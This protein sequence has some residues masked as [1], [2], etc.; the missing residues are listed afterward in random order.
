MAMGM[1]NRILTLKEWKKNTDNAN[2]F[3]S[4]KYLEVN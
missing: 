1:V 4:T 2:S 3:I